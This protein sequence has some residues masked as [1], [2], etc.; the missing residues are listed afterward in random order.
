MRKLALGLLAAASVMVSV[1]AHAQGFWFGAPG[2]GVG[3]GTGY[4]S[5][6]YYSD[7]YWGPGWGGRAYSSYGY[8]PAYSGYDS[9]AYAPGYGYAADYVYDEPSFTYS[10]P[11]YAV[12][13]EPTYER[14]FVRS[15]RYSRSYAPSYASTRSY[16]SGYAYA[17]SYRT[18]HVYTD[19]NR[20]R[21]RSANMIQTRAAT[22]SQ[23]VG[24]AVR[25][26]TQ[27]SARFR[28]RRG[29]D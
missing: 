21:V 12:E 20:S 11:R 17:P 27:P 22:S 5:G 15:A 3:I 7:A 9:Y 18:R 14:R 25:T 13:Y 29:Q 8:A 28:A 10:E 24:S 1:P 2:F 16:R 6:P 23:T 26:D 19:V 4:N